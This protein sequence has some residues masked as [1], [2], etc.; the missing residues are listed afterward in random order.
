MSVIDL[1][2]LSFGQPVKITANVSIGDGKIVDI[3]R[4]TELGGPIHSKGVLILSSYV[5][6]KF[7]PDTPLSFA[8]SLVFE[9]SYAG[10]EGDSATLAETCALL[11]ALAATPIRQTLAITGSMNQHGTAQVIGGVNEKIEGFFDICKAR[12]LTGDQGVLIPADNVK[13]LMLRSDVVEAARNGQFAVY[14]VATVDE[15]IAVLTGIVAGERDEE[16]RFP[17][18]SINGRVE[19]RLVELAELR[20]EFDHARK[21]EDETE[22]NE[23]SA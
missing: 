16:G 6:A 17:E 10:V 13:H 12:G 22:S 8:A 21:D 15:A 9:Q 11:S 14:P 23:D 2:R 19:R 4:E 18:E 3:E 5:S 7:A 1:G 20:R